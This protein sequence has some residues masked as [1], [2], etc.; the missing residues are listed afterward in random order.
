MA[1]KSSMSDLDR[2][3]L[4][5]ELEKRLNSQQNALLTAKLEIKKAERSVQK[6]RDTIESLETAIAE[7]KEQ[8][9]QNS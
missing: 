6:Y 8:M 7:T 4:G 3:I 2:E 1:T 5:M 9:A